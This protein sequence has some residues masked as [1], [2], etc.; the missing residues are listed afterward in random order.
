MRKVLFIMSQLTDQDVDWIATRG[1]R[2]R[3]DA[4]RELIAIN[5]RVD[6]VYFVIDGELE[7]LASGGA[8]LAELG[9]GEI[10]GE[11]TLVDPALTAVSVRAAV[12]TL[13]LRLKM[14]E[15]RAKLEQDIAF[16][17]CFYRAIAIFLADRM[18]NT[19]RRMGGAAAED[20][21]EAQLE[22][23]NESLLDGVHL[24]GARFDRMLKKLAG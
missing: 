1:E 17:A 5:S 19:T 7:V 21:G 18:R 14:T 16:A 6:S 2:L 22:D 20:G 8:R 12:P 13:L 4:G 15:L 24:A 10:V 9:S 23:L 11:M 3:I